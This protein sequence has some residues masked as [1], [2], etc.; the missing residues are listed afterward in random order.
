MSMLSFVF[1]ATAFAATMAT[2]TS[3]A[4]TSSK[5][6]M[7]VQSAGEVVRDSNDRHEVAT[8]EVSETE[9]EVD[10]NKETVANAEDD[11]LHETEEEAEEEEEEDDEAEEAETSYEEEEADGTP[12]AA[13]AQ[14]GNAPN[15]GRP[16][17][18]NHH[19]DP[20]PLHESS[21]VRGTTPSSLSEKAG[22][23]CLF[24]PVTQAGGANGGWIHCLA[25]EYKNGCSTPGQ[26]VPEC[27]SEDMPSCDEYR[28]RT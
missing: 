13:E 6:K 23:I 11:T 20:P 16:S 26:D 17:T 24:C 4:H 7:V 10:L 18:L 19:G 15:G 3:Q 1:I 27:N 9:K 21:L 5:I 2:L 12:N 25:D 14:A 8:V 28:K 22:S